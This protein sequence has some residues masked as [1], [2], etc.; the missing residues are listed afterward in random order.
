MYTI[1]NVNIKYVRNKPVI[2]YM[3]VHMHNYTQ[4][5]TIRR[6]CTLMKLSFSHLKYKELIHYRILCPLCKHFYI[7]LPHA[8]K[9]VTDPLHIIMTLLQWLHH[10]PVNTAIKIHIRTYLH[11][12][13]YKRIQY[14]YV[15]SCDQ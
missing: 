13:I 5:Y 9:T 4:I 14:M 12:C 8:D 11:V 7:T 2:K 6:I 15:H 3:Y 1:K 10:V